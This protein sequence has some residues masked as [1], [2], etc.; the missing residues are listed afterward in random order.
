[1]KFKDHY[2]TMGITPGATP[3]EIKAAYRVLARKYHPDVS[4]AAGTEKRFSELVEANEVLED[5][6]RR[7]A[8][9]QMRA[10]GWREGQEMDPPPQARGPAPGSRRAA[11]GGGTAWDGAD[12][13]DDETFQSWFAGATAQEAPRRR[14]SRGE[15]LHARFPLTLEEVYHGGERQF[16]LQADQDDAEDLDRSAQAQTP[17][18]ITVKIPKGLADGGTLRLRGQGRPGPG[19]A[20]AGDL[21]LDIVWL[22]HSRYA[23]SG[24]DLTLDLPLA[25]WEAVLGATII[26][27]TLG[28]NLSVIIPPDA[29]GGD[30]L[31]LKGRGLPGP[32][33]G[34]QFLRLR[35]VTPVTADAATREA[36]RALGQGS[37]FSPRATLG[38]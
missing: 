23:C 22:P 4:K 28:G 29:Q 27:P 6:A 24:R 26:V 8:Y 7:A 30:L 21:L 32:P 16:T 33:A 1:M 19:S 35:V 20:P 5:P 9:D 36:Y 38:V 31:R 34:D 25:P 18:T 13:T 37:P 14:P 12:F 15:D 17:R 10:A 11:H 2:R 3:K